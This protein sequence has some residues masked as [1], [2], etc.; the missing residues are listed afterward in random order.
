MKKLIND[1][2]AIKENKKLFDIN[3]FSKEKS[4]PH[5]RAEQITL[6]CELFGEDIKK[7]YGKWNGVTR[8][9]PVNTLYELRNEA[10]KTGNP[11]KRLFIYLVREWKKKY[12]K[13]T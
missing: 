12:I 8:L 2:P 11:P 1:T 3:R 7:N 9:L 13:K 10:E 6:L 5:P 4:A